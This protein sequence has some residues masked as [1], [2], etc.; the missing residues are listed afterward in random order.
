MKKYLLIFLL[1][2]LIMILGCSEKNQNSIQENGG[3][4]VNLICSNNKNECTDRKFNDLQSFQVFK[5][6]IDSAEKMPGNLNYIAE[7]NLKIKFQGQTTK[8]FHLSLGTDRDMKGLLVD[9][10][11]TNQG[12]EIPVIHAN[13]LRELIEG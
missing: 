2:T 4:S 7:Y 12:Y 10:E 11:N 6:T 9:L 8:T 5:T 3:V 13:K 1:L